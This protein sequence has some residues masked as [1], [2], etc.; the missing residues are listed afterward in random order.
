MGL[1][2]TCGEGYIMV[3]DGVKFKKYPYQ[4]NW[5]EFTEGIL[6]QTGGDYL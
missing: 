1:S 4:G 5:Q 6:K 2:V 3:T